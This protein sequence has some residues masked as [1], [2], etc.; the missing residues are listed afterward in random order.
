[1]SCHHWTLISS[2]EPAHRMRALPLQWR[3]SM[4]DDDRWR[5]RRAVSGFEKAD[6]LGGRVAGWL[7]RSEPPLGPGLPAALQPSTVKDTIDG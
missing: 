3:R 1:M 7:G 6:T 5:S 2:A 4:F